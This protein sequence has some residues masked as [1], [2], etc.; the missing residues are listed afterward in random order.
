MF[1]ECLWAG[2]LLAMPPDDGERDS[3]LQHLTN[4]HLVHKTPGDLR[5]ISS[6]KP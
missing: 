3:I 2:Y 6:L 4:I 1:N 5:E